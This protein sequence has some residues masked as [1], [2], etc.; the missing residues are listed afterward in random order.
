MVNI[1]YNRSITAFDNKTD[2]IEIVISAGYSIVRKLDRLLVYT[3]L[4]SHHIDNGL[5]GVGC[6]PLLDKVI[7]TPHKEQTIY[8]A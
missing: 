2:C 8:L 6:H 4:I 5:V 7:S 1:T 3:S